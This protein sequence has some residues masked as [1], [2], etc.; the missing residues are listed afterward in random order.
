VSRLYFDPF[1]LD[2][3][4]RLLLRGEQEIHITPK[5][6]QLLHTL[7]DNAPKAMSKDELFDLVWQGIVVAEVNLAS[8]INDLRVALGD[9][10]RHPKFIRTVHAYGY[11]F[12]APVRTETGTHRRSTRFHLVVAGNDVPLT[13]GE[14]IMG[15]DQDATV[16]VPDN[17]VSRRHARITV[18]DDSALLEDL[19][20]K[21]GTFLNGT[22]LA[23]PATLRPG[24]VI[25]VGS[26]TAV[27]RDL[28][29]T[30]STRTLGA[31]HD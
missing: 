25:T 20:S 26:I 24:D 27:F 5:A 13:P 14:H 31:V 15:R 30:E 9:D 22:R 18:K 2:L 11:A 3:D 4:R 6:F 19:G 17:A 16:V 8:T 10:A 28:G 1:I 21:N 23:E 29:T 12:V 7:A